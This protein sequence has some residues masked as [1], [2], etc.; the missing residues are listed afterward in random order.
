MPSRPVPLPGP[1]LAPLRA[2]AGSTGT[3]AP[4]NGLRQRFHAPSSIWTMALFAHGTGARTG[5]PAGNHIRVAA[6][7]AGR[8][9]QCTVTGSCAP[10][11]LALRH[12]RRPMK[13]R[14]RERRHPAGRM[15]ARACCGTR[16]PGARRTRPGG[17]KAGGPTRIRTW[18]QGIMRPLKVGFKG[19]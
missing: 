2:R 11:G 3:R 19:F 5:L 13:P 18:N 14:P 17:R 4:G 15:L 9:E 8:R 7:C 12:A 1:A 10:S 6:G 16:A